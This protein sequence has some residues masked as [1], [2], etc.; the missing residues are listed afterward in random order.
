MIAKELEKW[1]SDFSQKRRKY[2]IETE[3]GHNLN[4]QKEYDKKF[5]ELR[6]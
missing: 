3:F 1:V 5:N 6:G 2:D 4:K